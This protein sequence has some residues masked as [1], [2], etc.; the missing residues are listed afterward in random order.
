MARPT[1]MATVPSSPCLAGSPAS[2]ASLVTLLHEIAHIRAEHV[3]HVIDD[4]IEIPSTTAAEAAADEL[5]QRWALTEPLAINAPTSRAKVLAC[6]AQLGAHPAVVAGRLHHY[7][8]LPRSHLNNL[9]PN[10]R[11]HL[12]TRHSP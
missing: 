1:A 7:G 12:E 10:A 6:A 3:G 9:A 8:S 2:T 11:A 5:A 4:D